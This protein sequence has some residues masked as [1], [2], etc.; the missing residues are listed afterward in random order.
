MDV[1]YHLPPV[2]AL[3]HAEVVFVEPSPLIPSLTYNGV[4]DDATKQ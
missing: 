2:H 3:P 4:R 1:G